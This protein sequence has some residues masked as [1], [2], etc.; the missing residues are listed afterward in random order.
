M[1]EQMPNE[2]G[3]MEL[4]LIVPADNVARKSGQLL[5]DMTDREGGKQHGGLTL[6]NLN[7]VPTEAKAVKVKTDKFVEKVLKP[8]SSAMGAVQDKFQALA[9]DEIKL[10]LAVSAEGDIGVASAGVET[11]LEITFKYRADKRENVTKA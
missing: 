8:I 4:L 10:S 1:S 6:L 9:V 7:A 2:S 5:V 11:S 3:E